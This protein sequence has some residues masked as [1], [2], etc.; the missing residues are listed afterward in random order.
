MSEWQSPSLPH[1]GCTQPRRSPST[2]CFTSGCV[3]GHACHMGSTE[4]RE[5][6]QP[7]LPRWPR[8]NVPPIPAF[9]A[10]SR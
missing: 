9:P 6:W 8:L 4:C 5:H 7:T 3:V 1:K 10:R 2:S